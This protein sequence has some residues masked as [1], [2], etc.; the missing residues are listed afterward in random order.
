MIKQESSNKNNVFHTMDTDKIYECLE[1]GKSGLSETEAVKRRQL[2]GSNKI[3]K[4]KKR[5]LVRKI[6]EQLNNIMVMI[7]SIAAIIALFA[8]DIKSTIIIVF[9]IIMNTIL[10]IIQEG[11]AEKAMEA[12]QRMSS[13]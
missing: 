2:Y 6:W 12:L 10:G 11:K 5:T 7:L 9:V 13:P 4:D 8:G 1:T 3:N